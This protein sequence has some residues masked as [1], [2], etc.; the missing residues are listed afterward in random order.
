MVPSAWPLVL[1]ATTRLI[2]PP[3]GL[4][5]PQGMLQIHARVLPLGVINDPRLYRQLSRMYL[6]LSLPLSLSLSLCGGLTAP[7]P[8]LPSIWL[9]WTITSQLSSGKVLPGDGWLVEAR[10]DVVNM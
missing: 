2:Q 1:K 5:G 7:P 9:P 10:E 6:F 3:C 8:A 4:E